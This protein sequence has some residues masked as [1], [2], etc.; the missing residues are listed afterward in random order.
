MKGCS[1]S[2]CSRWMLLFH[3]LFSIAFSISW[4]GRREAEWESLNAC[5]WMGLALTP[6]LYGTRKKIWLQRHHVSCSCP[7][8]IMNCQY[9]ILET[10][11]ASVATPPN[12]YDSV[13][14]KWWLCGLKKIGR[15]RNRKKE[16]KGISRLTLHFFF[17]FPP[18]ATRVFLKI[19]FIN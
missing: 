16:Q 10:P 15:Q 11:K 9:L 13:H 17:S 18:I 7:P 3:Q 6:H 5:G 2:A 8:A 1:S 19:C 4:W 12:T 14:H